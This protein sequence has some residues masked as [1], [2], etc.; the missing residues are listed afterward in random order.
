MGKSQHGG[1]GDI[2]GYGARKF[3][4]SL[5]GESPPYTLQAR[6]NVNDRIDSSTPIDA[7][8]WYHVALVGKPQ[9]EGWQVELFLDG[10]SIATGLS[11][12]SNQETKITD[13]IVLGAE[14]YYLHD[15]YY[16]GEMGR[17]VV[18]N[19]SLEATEIKKLANRS[20]SLN[21]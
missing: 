13:S 16:R 19:T 5:I 10:D 15:A 6:I 20:L 4:L 2:I 17:V 12:M 9:A 1:K 7:N 8:R 11:K 3:I 18:L 14:L 21:P